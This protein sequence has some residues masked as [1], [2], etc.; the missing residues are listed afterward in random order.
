[1]FATYVCTQQESD[2]IVLVFS[3]KSSLDTFSDSFRVRLNSF[4]IKL[5]LWGCQKKRNTLFSI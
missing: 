2:Q 4:F 5:S 1:M 3:P